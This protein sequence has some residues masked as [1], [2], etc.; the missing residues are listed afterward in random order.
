M[1]NHRLTLFAVVAF[2]AAAY[3]PRAQEPTSGIEFGR[4][5]NPTTIV[6]GRIG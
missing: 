6:G 4:V 1:R 2:T 5:D 3:A